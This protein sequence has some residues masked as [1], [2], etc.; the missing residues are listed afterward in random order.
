VT[1]PAGLGDR[2]GN[3]PLALEAG[4]RRGRRLLVAKDTPQAAVRHLE[5]TVARKGVEV[6]TGRRGSFPGLL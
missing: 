5:I 6:G 1:R 2:L 3:W 4:S